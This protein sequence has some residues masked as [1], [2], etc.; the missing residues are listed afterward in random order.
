MSV[1]VKPVREK[2]GQKAK[3][4]PPINAEPE[5]KAPISHFFRHSFHH[6]QSFLVGRPGFF[7]GNDIF[8]GNRRITAVI[9]RRESRQ[10]RERDL[11]PAA[12]ALPQ[13]VPLIPENGKPVLQKPEI[14]PALHPEMT[15]LSVIVAVYLQRERL[16]KH[17]HH[18]LSLMN[19]E[20]ITGPRNLVLFFFTQGRDQLPLV[21]LPVLSRKPG[22]MKD[23]KTLHC[24]VHEID[25]TNLLLFFFFLFIQKQLELILGQ[26][27]FQF[28]KSIRQCHFSLLNVSSADIFTGWP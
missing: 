7:P 5:K 1:F 21:L 17:R 28:I 27:F 9:Q 10:L 22:L 23:Q 11:L 20:N 26:Q 24:V 13:V 15:H 18:S 16:E 12:K 8:L 19:H 3:R 2:T 25:Q 4:K 14:F 6:S